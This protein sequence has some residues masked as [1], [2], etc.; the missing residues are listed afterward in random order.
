MNNVDSYS[1][2]IYSFVRDF[3]SFNLF[4][5]KNHAESLLINDGNVDALL[6]IFGVLLSVVPLCIA[7]WVW[8]LALLL[9]ACLFDKGANSPFKAGTNAV[10]FNAEAGA[11]VV[12]FNVPN[13][14]EV[15]CA[16]NAGANVPIGG[17]ANCPF[18]IGAVC[19]IGAATDDPFVVGTGCTFD[20]EVNCPFD[21]G[22]TSP[23]VAG[24]DGPYDGAGRPYEN[25]GICHGYWPAVA[26]FGWKCAGVCALG[27][28]D[29]MK[30]DW[31]GP[32]C[33]R[34]KNMLY[35]LFAKLWPNIFA[36][37]FAKLSKPL[38]ATF[39]NGGRLGLI[40]CWGAAAKLK[41]GHCDCPFTRCISNKATAITKTSL[42]MRTCPTSVFTKLNQIDR[43]EFMPSDRTQCLLF[44]L[45]ITGYYFT[46]I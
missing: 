14:G 25:E 4:H 19:P 26:P 10:P 7:F 16:F 35:R 13:G 38:N 23:F 11:N 1:C 33:A 2:W 5:A 28:F 43:I 12:P 17:R 27:I 6:V 40:G 39:G 18:D 46:L 20:G 21:T 37:P 42:I 32:C 15:N 30:F 45:L 8:T 34:P 31:N 24:A 44:L 22:T 29:G 41:N 3:V 36:R 9:F